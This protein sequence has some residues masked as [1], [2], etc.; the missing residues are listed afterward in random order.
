MSKALILSHSIIS[1]DPRPLRQIKWLRESGFTEIVSVG[2][3]EK[4]GGV[5]RHQQISQKG[6]LK[7]Y[8]GYLIRNH[9]ARFSYFFGRQLDQIPDDFFADT[10]VLIINE[11]E[12]LPWK[13]LASAA[14]ES[15]PVYLD[16][17]EDHVNDAHR[18]LLE[19]VAFKSYW[20]W[21][22]TR[23]A[24]FVVERKSKLEMTCV[25]G[26]IAADY[27]RLTNRE[28]AL[29]FNAPD[30]NTL[31]PRPVNPDQIRLIH[32]GMGTKGRGI[33]TA[34]QALA[35]LPGHFTLDLVLFASPLFKTKIKLMARRLRVSERLRLENGVPLSELPERLNRAD[36]AIV[37]LSTVT[38]GHINA[39]PNKFFESIHAKLAVVTGPNPSMARLT[40]QHGFGLA[41]QSWSSSDLADSLRDLSPKEIEE[42]KRKAH[43]ASSALSSDQSRVTFT[44]LMERLM[45]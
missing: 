33:E 28:V 30:V 11:I 13:G 25:E 5:D 2:L 45:R 34:L 41:V 14:L 15:L 23:F 31:E 27:R 8:V 19:R 37:V 12:Y 9:R 39:L 40:E 22:L 24:S 1:R 17:H 18:G 32:H 29:L 42:F 3:G 6:L 10:D 38:K 16:L 4:P 26:Q 20:D 7:R 44:N 36:I 35:K 43:V 21:Q